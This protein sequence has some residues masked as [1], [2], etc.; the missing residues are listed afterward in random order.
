[1]AGARNCGIASPGGGI[2]AVPG[3]EEGSMPEWACAADIPTGAAVCKPGIACIGITDG[4]VGMLGRSVGAE[5]GDPN[6]DNPA[7]QR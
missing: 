4:N 1:M 7:G 5:T 3:M 6:F 2:I